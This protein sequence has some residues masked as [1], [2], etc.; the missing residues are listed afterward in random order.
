MRTR[1]CLF[2]S[3]IALIA[4]TIINLYLLPSESL[5]SSLYAIAVLIAALYLHPRLVGAVGGLAIAL[6]ISTAAARQEPAATQVVAAFGLLIVSAL[7]ITLGTQRREATRR[8]SESEI[9]RQELQ[10]FLGMVSHDLGQPLTSIHGYAQLLARRRGDDVPTSEQR[11]LLAITDAADRMGRLVDD[12]RDAARIGAGQF[13]VDVSPCDLVAVVRQIVEE[14]QATTNRHELVLEAPSRLEGR[15]DPHRLGHLCTNLIANA[16]A[17]TP[18][19][20]EVRIIIQC[21]T[22]EAWL[23]VRDGGIGIAAHERARLFQPFSRLTRM[24]SGKGSGLGLPISKAI[25]EAHGGRIWVRSDLGRGST[26][27]AALP[28]R[29]YHEGA[30][31]PP[32]V[33]IDPIHDPCAKGDHHDVRQSSARHHRAARIGAARGR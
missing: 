17:Y 12:L 4:V 9:R 18:D 26:F 7:A 32:P 21:V 3:G 15:W 24:N 31:Q 11:A 28:L 20:G 29:C 27:I 1:D 22:G 30:W 6:S 23:S 25:V 8:A 2:L 14:Q 16:I 33:R 5:A 10:K 13:A 19:G